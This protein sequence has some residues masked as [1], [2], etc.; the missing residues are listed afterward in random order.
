M[1]YYERQGFLQKKKTLII[2]FI[3]EEGGAIFFE[4]SQDVLCTI[5][6]EYFEA[7]KVK[8]YLKAFRVGLPN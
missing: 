4:F 8:R 2:K 6:E 5:S 3:G 1:L 7:V